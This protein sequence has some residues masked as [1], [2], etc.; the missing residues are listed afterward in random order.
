MVKSGNS[1]CIGY[2]WCIALLQFFKN[3]AITNQNTCQFQFY[4]FLPVLI[5]LAD[6]DDGRATANSVPDPKQWRSPHCRD[7]DGGYPS[8]AT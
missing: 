4:G 8:S 5:H 3:K 6:D 2:I 7:G 1:W